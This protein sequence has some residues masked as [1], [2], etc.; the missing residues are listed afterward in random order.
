M[1]A[2]NIQNQHRE[3]VLAVEGWKREWKV[4]TFGTNE[5]YKKALRAACFDA[6]EVLREFGSEL[7]RLGMAVWKIRTNSSAGL[8]ISV[9]GCRTRSFP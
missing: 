2:T 4:A 9:G 3:A 6:E 5:E 7:I 1:I 8:E